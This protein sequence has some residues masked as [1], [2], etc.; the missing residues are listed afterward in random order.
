MAIPEWR[1]SVLQY[2]E[3]WCRRRGRPLST[4]TGRECRAV[5]EGLEL[6]FG[7]RVVVGYVR[8]GM[9]LIDAEQGEQAGDGIGC[10]RGAAVGVD[11]EGRD[12]A[13]GFDG[14]GDEFFRQGAGLGG[15]DF[16]ADDLAGEDVQD[17]VQLIPDP[18][19]RAFQLGDVPRTRPG[20]ARWPS[21]RVSS[22]PGRWPGRAVR[23]TGRARAAAG[24]WWPPSTG[25]CPRPARSHKPGPV[26]CPRT[27]ASPAPPARAPAP[28]RTAPPDGGT[29]R[30]AGFPGAAR[31]CAAGTAP[32]G[33]SPGSG[34][35]GWCRSPP[36]GQGNAHR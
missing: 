32:R 28:G 5:F 26:T 19:G 22:W 24:T 35:P 23:R 4:R 34:T 30:E 1:C 21:A 29:A 27:A 12:P 14:T 31:E 7:V 13:V 36:P 6:G 15:P 33:I 2:Q 11:G 9:R 16:P 17:G 3:N 20:S 18:A 10:H 8:P 25:R